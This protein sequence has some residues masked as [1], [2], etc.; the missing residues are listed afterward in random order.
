M[1]LALVATTISAVGVLL[2]GCGCDGN[3][4]QRTNEDGRVKLRLHN[5]L[6][7]GSGKSPASDFCWVSGTADRLAACQVGTRYP[8]CSK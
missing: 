3:V 2:A 7:S 5:S 8:E 1:R 6:S 4:V